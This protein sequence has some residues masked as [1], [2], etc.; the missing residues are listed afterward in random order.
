MP[1]VAGDAA[2]DFVNT[3]E[4]RGHPQAGDALRTPADLLLFGQRYGLLADS[5]GPGGAGQAELRRARQARELLYTI[6]FARVHDRPVPQADLDRLAQLTAAAYRAASLLPGANG[7]VRWHWDPADLATVRHVAVAR[8]VGLLQAEVSPRLKQCPGD[9]CGWFFIDTTKR[10]NRRWCQM[11]ECGQE[12][13][14]A[15]RRARRQERGIALKSS[16]S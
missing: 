11:S 8:A 13:K 16:R 14:D 1:F 6:L 10:G 3:A 5:A 2:L 9:H 15:H 4:E 7:S 12:A